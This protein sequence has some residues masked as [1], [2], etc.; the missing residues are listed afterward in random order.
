MKDKNDLVERLLT[1]DVTTR[2]GTE[3]HRKLLEIYSLINEIIESSDSYM[4]EDNND[5]ALYIRQN[6]TKMK[7]K[8]EENQTNIT[9]YLDKIITKLREDNGNN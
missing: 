3:M 1:A 6:M 7:E 9:I 8:L 2:K 4:L 5:V